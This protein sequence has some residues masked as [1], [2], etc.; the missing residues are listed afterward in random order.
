MGEHRRLRVLGALGAG[1]ALIAGVAIVGV[2]FLGGQVSKAFMPV[3]RM[4]Y[5]SPTMGG[6]WDVACATSAP[7]GNPAACSTPL[8]SLAPAAAAQTVP[9]RVSALDVPVTKLGPLEVYLGEATLANGVLRDASFHLDGIDPCVQVLPSGLEVGDVIRLDVR[10]TDPSRPG[11]H[12]GYVHGWHPGVET[13]KAYLVLD[14]T[15]FDPGTVLK[16]RDVLVR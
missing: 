13:V 16:I 6:Y 9:L 11:F 14:V 7:D 15:K 12:N 3:P 2:V 10:S 1:L 8:P 5:D 4:V